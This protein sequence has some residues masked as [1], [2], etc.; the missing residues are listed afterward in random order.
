LGA[1]HDLALPV[2]QGV[3]QRAGAADDYRRIRALSERLCA[4]LAVEDY[5]IQAAVE[6]SPP[7]WHLAHVSWFFET[8][9]LVPYLRGYKTFDRRYDYLFNS[10]YEQ[11]G[12]GFWPR[13]ER[14]LLSRPTVADVYAYRAHVDSAM[15]R[16]IESADAAAWAEV[17]PL[18]G[19]GLNHE[20]QHQ[21][22]L[23]TDI[24][25]TFAYNPLRPAYRDDLPAPEPAEPAP[26]T[27]VEY[28]G[29]LVEIGAGGEGFTYD[30]ERPC[31]RVFL[32]PYR[33]ADRPVTNREY[34]E[35]IA[36]GG[37][38]KPSL[39]LADGWQAVKQRGWCAPLYWAPA[40]NGW[41]QMTLGGPRPLNPAEPVVH[42]SYYEADAFA[43]WAG[44]RLPS[45]AEWEQAASGVA[46]QGN[47]LE[48]GRLHPAPAAGR[49][50]GA[51]RQ[52]FGD[53]WEWTASAY[54]PYPGF[55]APEGALGE[56]NGKFMCNQMV[57][58]GGSCATSA[59]HV[60]ATYRNFFYPHERWQFKGFRLAAG[61]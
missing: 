43:T 49:C 48:S 37:Y 14:G 27:F 50:E 10:Y 17:G 25:F 8:F 39:W 30:N 9:L 36:D 53:V 38:Q 46:V 3:R 44:K 18:L 2:A 40:D 20:Q 47:L 6:T 59:D 41:T 26:L 55:R 60:R 33:L 28:D 15:G 5:Q 34:L 42:V 4:P 61:R 52:L 13:P 21:E 23:L 1:N 57:L 31:H 35:F 54:L 11:L 51:P 29:G 45:E 58:R 12:S 56:Y 19:I 32:A 24:K 7:K 22:L 16:L